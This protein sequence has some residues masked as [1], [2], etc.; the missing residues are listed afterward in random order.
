VNVFWALSKEK[1]YGPLFFLET[2]ITGIVYLNMKMMTKTA[3]P[4]ITL[5]KC[6]STSTPFFQ[7]GELAERRR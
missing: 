2:A 3:H 1:V 7:V 6:A 4:H 5:E